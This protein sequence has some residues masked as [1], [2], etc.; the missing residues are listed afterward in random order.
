MSCNYLLVIGLL[1]LGSAAAVWVK[2]LVEKQRQ[3]RVER[4][5]L[6]REARELINNFDFEEES[7]SDTVAYSRLRPYL[8]PRTIA[9]IEGHNFGLV[10]GRDRGNQ[11]VRNYI[12]DDV[13]RIENELWNL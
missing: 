13:A 4:M 2:W 12:L 7:F 1:A 6:I 11:P 9:I 5:E 8:S 3:T 10:V